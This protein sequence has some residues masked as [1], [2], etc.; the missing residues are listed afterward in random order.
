MFKTYHNAVFQVPMEKLKKVSPH[1]MEGD[2]GWQ[3]RDAY[4]EAYDEF[5]RYV[6]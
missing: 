1:S 3:L 2:T 4:K 6:L 5:D